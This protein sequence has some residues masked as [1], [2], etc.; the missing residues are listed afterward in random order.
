MKIKISATFLSL[1]LMICPFGAAQKE[2][3]PLP[4]TPKDFSMPSREIFSL[5]NGLEVVLV[6]YGN[7]PKTMVQVVVRAGNSDEAPDEVW[8]ADLSGNLLKEGTSTLTAEGLASR[9]AGMGGAIEVSVGADQTTVGLEVLSEFTPQAIALLGNVLTDPL[10]P[11]SEIERLKG[12]LLRELSIQQTQPG[13]IALQK[14]REVLYGEHPYGRVFPTEEMIRSFNLEK[15]EDFYDSNFG[16]VRS[17]LYILG[18]FDA[19]AAKRA[20]REAFGA[21]R[22]GV[23]SEPPLAR[24][25][26]ERAVY[27]VDRPD[28]PQ[29]NIMIGL[30]V[31]DPSHSDYLPLTVM[32]T[33]L[34]GYFSSRITTNIREDKGY[35]YSPYSTV[36]VRY[37]DAYWVET[38]NVA[39]EV[40]GPAVQEIL[41]EIERLR[42]EPPP[43]EELKGVQNYMSGSFVRQNSSKA[44]IAAQLAFLRL[45][46][47]SE[48]Y[49]LDYVESVLAVG[50]E[51]VTAMAT[52][53]IRPDE[54]TIVVVG[55]REKVVEQMRR[56]GEIKE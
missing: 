56:F 15:V 6:P 51:T 35:T 29:S 7:I 52:K 32:N 31:T 2:E 11:E 14:F 50:P 28:A 36:S 33:L 37:R 40:T 20:V 26:S 24:P 10:L 22:T 54:L 5:D 53:Y 48:S 23:E 9:A 41:S 42:Q 44:G 30:P 45:H 8:L 12:D 47:L 34:G 46:G 27:L 1:V 3:P 18:K 21:W 25:R 16:A 43:E 49:L 17:D 19:E 13:S 38:A 4:G 39:T 55:D